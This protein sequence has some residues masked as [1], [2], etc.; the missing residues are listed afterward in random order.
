MHV[1]NLNVA[2]VSYLH[3]V[4]TCICKV[5]F[6]QTNYMLS[7]PF[8][9]LINSSHLSI[10]QYMACDCIQEFMLH[11]YTSKYIIL[12]LAMNTGY[13]FNVAEIQ[14]F[15]VTWAMVW[16]IHFLGIPPK[17][18]CN[19]WCRKLGSELALPSVSL[20]RLMLN[21]KCCMTKRDLSGRS[22][23]VVSGTCSY[24]CL[25]WCMQ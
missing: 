13:N 24:I 11:T 21:L 7:S 9:V 20:L 8:C 12:S 22:G 10:I 3:V 19:S 4:E 25:Q 5:M 16:E 2:V 18:R 17:L 23:D 1:A 6:C 15:T 14:T